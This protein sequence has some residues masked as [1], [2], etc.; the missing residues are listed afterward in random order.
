MDLGSKYETSDSYTVTTILKNI[1]GE[2]IE[3]I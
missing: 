1:L 3:K 2:K